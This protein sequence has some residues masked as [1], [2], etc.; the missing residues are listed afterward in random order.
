MSAAPVTLWDMA[1][2]PEWV[3]AVDTAAGRRYEVR[4]HAQR[5][6]DSCFQHKKRFKS[7]EEAMKWRSTNVSEVGHGTHVAPSELTV[8]QA[9]DS[10]LVGQRIRASTREGYIAN[11]RPLADHLGERT[12]TVDHQG[13]HRGRRGSAS[14]REFAD[15][16]VA[17]T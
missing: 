16:H 8:R 11:L 10:W 13:R 9:A 17:C 3:K 4:V 5:G 6:D 15:G 1:R 7:V 2:T 12:R 14:R